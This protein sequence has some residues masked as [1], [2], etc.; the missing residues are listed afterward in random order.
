VKGRL[1]AAVLAYGCVLLAGSAARADQTAPKEITCK[2]ELPKGA[3]R[4]KV[5]EKFPGEVTAGYGATLDL[6]IRH[7][8]GETPLPHGFKIVAGSGLGKELEAS[9]FLLAAPPN[10][11]DNFFMETKEDG[12]G[13][14]TRVSIPFV[15]APNKS[16]SQSLTLPQMP[17]TIGRANGDVMTLC[18]QL[19]LVTAFDPTAGEED[20][21]PHPNADPRAEIEPWPIAKWILAAL[22]ALLVLAIILTWWVR[23]Q[24]KYLVPDPDAIRK[25]PWEEAMVELAEH[26][27]SDVF[28]ETAPPQ[29]VEGETA[30]A[31][32][33]DKISDTLRK[34]LGGRYG[35]EGL[36]FDGLET[37]TDEM[38]GLLRRVRPNVPRV[39]LVREFLAECDLVKFARV[40]PDVA[41]CKLALER[42]E[43]IVKT[44]IP[45]AAPTTHGPGGPNAG[46][47]G[48]P[49]AIPPAP[50]YLR[51]P[52]PRAAAPPR[53]GGMRL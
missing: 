34:Y 1:S 33:F 44:T 16:G 29:G 4:P 37:T 26:R 25:L 19:H 5:K 38:M 47:P 32:L 7:G 13:A 45:V 53:D 12:S 40:V 10:G 49:G 30:R 35:F 36:G 48:G 41:S 43:A 50:T 24:V 9:G 52:P 6:E 14:I 8:K 3:K 39:D 51:E 15:V 27:R 28:S 2:E 23:R 20:P 42:A 11:A 21:K 17:Y 31:E 18:T 46:T 22:I